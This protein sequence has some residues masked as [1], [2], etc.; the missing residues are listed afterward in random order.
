[1]SICYESELKRLRKL[2]QL[3]YCTLIF[4][5]YTMLHVT[6][7]ISQLVD[8]VYK[9]SSLMVFSHP[10]YSLFLLIFSFY[11]VIVFYGI[12]HIYGKELPCL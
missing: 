3:T 11:Y 5:T 2:S 7:Q 12:P 6:N 4:R 10:T 9:L 8:F 1:M